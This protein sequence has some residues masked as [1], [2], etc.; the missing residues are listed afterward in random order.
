[1]LRTL[2]LVSMLAAAAACSPQPQR[3]TQTQLVERGQYLVLNAGCNDCHTPGTAQGPDMTRSLQGSPLAFGPVQGVEIPGWVT[4]AP[5][6]AGLPQDWTEEQFASFMQTGVRPNGTHP[7][8]PMPPYRWNEEDAR[9]IA[10]YVH[11]L[12]KAEH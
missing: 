5:P 7:G 2:M 10:A 11:S 6:V 8:I 3:M 4:V 12:P 9:A 1:M